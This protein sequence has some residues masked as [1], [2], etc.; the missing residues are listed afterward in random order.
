MPLVVFPARDEIA[1]SLSSEQ[2][3]EAAERIMTAGDPFGLVFGLSL[4]A[5]RVGEPDFVEAGS[6]ILERLRTGGEMAGARFTLFAAAAMAAYGCVYQRR[7]LHE[8]PAFYRRLIALTFAG[9]LTRVLLE[10]GVD[11]NSM[12]KAAR[13]ASGLPAHIQGWRDRLEEPLWRPEWLT[14]GGVSEHVRA[15]AAEVV[16]ALGDEGPESWK[17]RVGDTQ[18]ATT[19]ARRSALRIQPGPLDG[20]SGEWQ[21][22]AAADA[23]AELAAMPDLSEQSVSMLSAVAYLGS[24]A[25][26]EKTLL[27][28]MLNRKLRGCLASGS[29]CDEGAVA[30]LHLTG[31][32]RTTELADLAFA[33]VLR[34]GALG[35]LSPD[36][37]LGLVFDC[38]AAASDETTWRER[39]RAAFERL[40][41]ADISAELAGGLVQGIEAAT[42][43]D[44]ALA[45]ALA[46]ARVAAALKA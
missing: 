17:I 18:R 36:S 28:A 40:A 11:P 2:L 22:P 30:T 39:L 5:M 8:E 31:R 16:F 12:W 3:L 26:V 45:P 29:P 37:A 15:Q 7:L 21:G 44:P 14:P 46:R 43:G 33:C 42:R 24:L 20:F 38:A 25:D 10:T 35:R 27:I 32:L 23:V 41:S 1:S 6:A 9:H 19:N 4:C 34:T 13:H